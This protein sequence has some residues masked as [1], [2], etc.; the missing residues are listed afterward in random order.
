MGGPLEIHDSGNNVRTGKTAGTCGYASPQPRR[1]WAQKN[2]CTH[3][4]IRSAARCGSLANNTSLVAQRHRGS[5]RGPS[6]HVGAPSA[7]CG[8][9]LTPLRG[10]P[11]ICTCPVL[12]AAAKP[13]HSF[14]C[15][16]IRCWPR[17]A[18]V[19]LA[20]RVLLRTCRTG[21]PSLRSCCGTGCA[22][23]AVC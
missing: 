13:T 8:S 23:A 1:P 22:A 17:C 3:S 6:I 19:A 5:K 11:S 21:T 4:Y 14:A 15:A 12:S 7:V 16:A 9:Q 2:D 20:L 10:L 18:R